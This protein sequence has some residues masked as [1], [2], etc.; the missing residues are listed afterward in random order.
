MYGEEREPP[1]V[2]WQK[3]KN[4][5]SESILLEEIRPRLEQIGFIYVCKG[6]WREL[7]MKENEKEKYE[8]NI[9]SD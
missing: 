6:Y 7:F 9:Q 8:I 2:G 5:S 3:N 4:H 1:K